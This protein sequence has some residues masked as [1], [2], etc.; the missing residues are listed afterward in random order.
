M[1]FLY[2]EVAPMWW[3]IDVPPTPPPGGSDPDGLDGPPPPP[4]RDPDTPPDPEFPISGYRF[5]DD[6]PDDF[7]LDFPIWYLDEY[8]PPGYKYTWVISNLPP[9]D[10]GWWV[11]RS[12]VFS[13][14][15]NLINHARPKDPRSY[16]EIATF[17]AGS[18]GA[19]GG[20]PGPSTIF[21]NHLIYAEGNYIA[22]VTN[23]VIRI[24]DGTFDREV[25]RVPNASSSVIPKAVMTMITANDTIY[26]STFDSGTT[27]ANWSGRVFSLSIE[28]GKIEPIGDPLT[29]GHMPYAL[30]W[31]MGRLWCGTNC[32]DPT[33]P[34]K[35]FWI[36]P[37]ID[38]AW[39]ED[40][41]LSTG[42]VSSLK[43]FKGLLYVGTTAPAATFAKVLVRSA[44][45]TYTT[46]LTATGGTA[47]AN[48]GFYALGEFN[49]NLYATFWNDDATDVAKIY[50]FDGSSWTTSYTGSGSTLAPYVGLL[51][52][53]DI[54]LAI[55]GGMGKT[56]VLLTTPDGT[57]WN[58]RSIFL[59]QGDPA[60]TGI[61]VFGTVVR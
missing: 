17:A 31:H 42:G 9:T 8:Y 61:P 49:S 26:L 50:K 46:S 58:N 22:G 1:P 34:G 54:L 5:D 55:G 36:R 57:T 3:N 39:T 29:T 38:T 28:T 47:T 30:V 41:T 19:L 21:N 14:Q 12:E 51:V 23:P 16:Q 2:Y 20:S 32:Q 37:G 33:A 48:N 43:T 10:T 44:F 56:A 24:F 7:T 15:G 53:S 27:S 60:S 40:Y 13:G 59:T 18:A 25:I 35:I 6:K 11:S 52:D 45:G 4:P